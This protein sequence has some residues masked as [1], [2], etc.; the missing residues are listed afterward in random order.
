[1]LWGCGLRR[2]WPRRPRPT[3]FGAGCAA[4]KRAAKRAAPQPARSSPA[5][6]ARPAAAQARMQIQR[7]LAPLRTAIQRRP[8]S[9]SGDS[10]RRWPATAGSGHGAS[11]RGA[12]R[13][14]DPMSHEGGAAGTAL[15]ALAAAVGSQADDAS[16]LA[17]QAAASAALHAAGARRLLKRCTAPAARLRRAAAANSAREPARRTR[18]AGERPL[19]GRARCAALRRVASAAGGATVRHSTPLARRLPPL[20][21][22]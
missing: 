6:S 12:S 9:H 2:A 15:Q 19:T 22:Q 10:S 4:A 1:M 5:S 11:S 13:G 3:L 18:A 7:S 16:A 8:I 17:L 20:R 14:P 21:R